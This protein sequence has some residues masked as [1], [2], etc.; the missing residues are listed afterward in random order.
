MPLPGRG[1]R[2]CPVVGPFLAATDSLRHGTAMTRPASVSQIRS[3]FDAFLYA[4]VEERS[5]RPLLSVISALARLDVDPWLEAAKLSHMSK[6]R[7]A[8]RL[9]AL[10]ETLPGD[11][12]AHIN[13]RAAAT[14]LIAL[15]PRR[16]AINVPLR[17]EPSPRE[18]PAN[19]RTIMAL[20]ML[21]ALFMALFFGRQH[22]AADVPPAAQAARS[23]SPVVNS[24][25]PA[26]PSRSL[27]RQNQ[28][29]P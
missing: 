10:I 14:R 11:P 28:K 24:V 3:E 29:K 7:A 2:L 13:C 1:H 21:N 23:Q 4:S 12:S 5:D 18:I 6:E 9:A 17:E 25:K 15:L 16:I 26:S 19:V 27:T 8:W 22:I 20:L